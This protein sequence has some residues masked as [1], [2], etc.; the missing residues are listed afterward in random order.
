MADYFLGEIRLFSFE[1]A[2]VDWAQCNG[3]IL[4]VKQ[5]PALNSL[6]HAYFGGDGQTTFALPD[7]RGRVAVGQTSDN[8]ANGVGIGLSGGSET[9]AIDES[10]MP[11]HQ[12]SIAASEFGDQ[13]RPTSNFFGK[14]VP[15]FDTSTI[16]VY[17]PP[18]DKTLVQL[19]AGMLSETGQSLEHEN[20][21]P[22]IAVEFC[23]S[24]AGIYPTR[25]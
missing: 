7:F 8:T 24:L 3:Q 2:P 13:I 11:K 5:N 18:A 22:S 1:F 12:H 25:W 23:I 9:V 14:V 4:D 17:A 16:R 10:T 20:R 21:Q 19:E 15:I 6:I